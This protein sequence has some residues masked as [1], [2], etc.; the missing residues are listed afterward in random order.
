MYKHI[1][2]GLGGLFIGLVIGFLGAN[3]LNRSGA[4]QTETAQTQGSAPILNPQIQNASVK[5]S[6]GAMMGD[7]NQTLEAAKNEPQN[8]EAQLKAGEMYAQ[9][10]NADKAEIYFDNAAALKPNEYDKIVRLGNAFFDIK[11]Y[12]KAGLLYE[13]ALAVN[14]KDINVRT[15]LGITFVERPDPD[16]ERGIR[17][18]AASLDANPKHE[19]TLYNLAYAH[20]K[21]G[22][23]AGARKYLAQ[24]EEVNPAS[25]TAAK[26][27]QLIV[28]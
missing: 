11:K 16:Y 17:E 21:K 13:R 23:K 3:S 27:K 14:P 28:N 2:T 7:V 18:F 26:L 20:Y 5:E 10:R 8:F 22:D 15:D 6:T 24:L 12:E 9:I 1:L 4:M 25:A 19:A